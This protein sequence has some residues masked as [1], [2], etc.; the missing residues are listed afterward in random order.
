MKQERLTEA[1][2]AQPNNQSGYQRDYLSTSQVSTSSQGR[3][4]NSSQNEEEAWI[5]TALPETVVHSLLLSHIL[6]KSHCKLHGLSQNWTFVNREGLILCCA[7]N[8][9]GLQLALQKVV[10]FF[11]F[12]LYILFLVVRSY[13]YIF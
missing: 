7:G 6:P 3:K 9:S 11:C 10:S 13:L 4:L 12:H 2:E 1:T 5:S 8:P